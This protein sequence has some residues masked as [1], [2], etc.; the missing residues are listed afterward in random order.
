[1]PTDAGTLARYVILPF[2][3]SEEPEELLR[4]RVLVESLINTY[5]LPCFQRKLISNLM[6]CV[7]HKGNDLEW[8]EQ[9]LRRSGGVPSLRDPTFAEDVLVT[10][11]DTV[12]DT[13][14]F[15]DAT[16]YRS[17]N[18]GTP[19]E[20]ALD[21]ALSKYIA[22]L[23]G[24]VLFK[25]GCKLLIRKPETPYSVCQRYRALLEQRDKNNPN[26][27]LLVVQLLLSFRGAR[28]LEEPSIF[29]GLYST[30]I[31]D[32][33]NYGTL[34][35][36]Q[37]KPCK[38]PKSYEAE[39]HSLWLLLR[40]RG[41]EV[42]PL[43]DFPIRSHVSRDS[44]ICL[45]TNPWLTSSEVSKGLAI[46][47]SLLPTEIDTHS[48]IEE[49]AL[50][51]LS[52]SYCGGHLLEFSNRMPHAAQLIEQRIDRNSARAVIRE[53]EIDEYPTDDPIILGVR[54]YKANLCLDHPTYRDTGPRTGFLPL[55]LA[56]LTIVKK[57]SS[58]ALQYILEEASRAGHRKIVQAY[59]RAGVRL[60][61]TATQTH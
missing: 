49:A 44:I 7:L 30:Y 19:G 12:V 1:M 43:T 52:N 23:C 25:F 57:P 41:S 29:S 34:H 45:L 42:Y 36:D 20:N 22:T 55:A 3:F 5:G 54:M 6:A 18:D 61:G 24:P 48:L 2:P 9:F 27:Q 50:I 46:A 33:P 58:P 56:I 59:E 13:G 4:S 51:T 31:H 53:P 40:L 37:H 8:Y 47:G 15:G 39:V 28:L 17:L 21:E 26:F 35:E 10:L 32:N 14:P 38:L 11:F 16:H 60:L